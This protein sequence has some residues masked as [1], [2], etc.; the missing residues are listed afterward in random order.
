MVAFFI[1]KD[2]RHKIKHISHAGLCL[3]TDVWLLALKVI[4]VNRIC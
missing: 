2:K 4:A 3:F 1:E